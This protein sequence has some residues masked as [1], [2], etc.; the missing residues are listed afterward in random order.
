MLRKEMY[1]NIRRKISL[2]ISQINTS[3]KTAGDFNRATVRVSQE[4]RIHLS[5]KTLWKTL[6]CVTGD[7][8][9]P[10]AGLAKGREREGASARP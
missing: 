2:D 4:Q 10:L 7:G 6:D 1:K 5:C 3:L 8:A 9:Q